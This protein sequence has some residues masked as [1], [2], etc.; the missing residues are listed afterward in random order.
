MDDMDDKDNLGT[1][2]IDLGTTNS[3]VGV[4]KNNK[5]EIVANILGERLTPSIIALL[6]KD[7]LIGN[8]AKNHMARNPEKT[9]YDAKRLIGRKF[10]NKEVQK[11]KK[12]WFFQVTNKDNDK[13][14]PMIMVNI[15]EKEKTFYPEIISALI[16]KKLKNDAEEYLVK[17]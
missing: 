13:D 15:N 6:E 10:S 1:I 17:K 3:C 4:W 8:S 5:V 14:K 11:N 2:G 12:F 16:L 7:L 9:I